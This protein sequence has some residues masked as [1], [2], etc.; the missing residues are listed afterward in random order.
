MK[1]RTADAEITERAT[2]LN[3]D[4]KL[5]KLVLY[6]LSYARSSKTTPCIRGPG[7]QGR[8]QIRESIQPPPRTIAVVETAA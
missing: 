6:Q 3:H 4:H 1:R 7:R 5:G 8:D 2:G